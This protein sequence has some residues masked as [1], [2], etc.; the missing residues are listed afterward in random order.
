M[1]PKRGK[2]IVGEDVKP[3]S[4]SFCLPSLFLAT[5][6]GVSPSSF[7]RPTFAPCSSSNVTP[8]ISPCRAVLCRAVLPSVFP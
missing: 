3:A 5:S 1:A 4:A 7:Y 2:T 6:M 8:A